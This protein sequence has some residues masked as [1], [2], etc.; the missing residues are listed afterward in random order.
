MSE[1]N[2]V[3]S[4][5]MW[6]FTERGTAQIFALIVQIILARLL[7]PEDFGILAVLLVFVNVSNV[8]IQKGFSTA[9]V[10]KKEAKDIDLN[11]VLFCSELFALV[12]YILLWIVAPIISKFYSNHE[13]INYI[14]VI[15]I[16]LFFGAFYSIE[17]S[18]LIR[19]MKFRQLFYSS[20][21]STVISGTIGIVLAFFEM[22]CW[23]LIAQNV[24]QQILFAFTSFR[25]CEWKVKIQYSK[26]SFESIFKFGSKVLLSEILYT[27]VENLRTLLI[28]AKFSTTD[29]AYYDRGQ[30]YPSVAMRSIYD[31]LGSVLLPV[32][33]S[34]QDKLNI[35]RNKIQ[36]FLCVSFYII[37][38]LFV[39]FA[40]IADSFTVIFLTEKWLPAVPFIHV[41][42][43]YQLGIL[44]YCVLRHGL[45]AIGK[46]DDGLKLEIIKDVLTLIS[47]IIGL[48][49]GTYEIA[50]FSMI[51]IWVA[52]YFYFLKMNEYISL[53]K[54]SIINEFIKVCFYCISMTIILN[55]LNYFITSYVLQIIVD[56][57][58]GGT[59]Y[60]L[61]SIV[62][63]DNCFFYIV[64]YVKLLYLKMKKS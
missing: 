18:I 4:S 55:I 61:L 49:L 63:K 62:L 64:K 15:S 23:A 31:A 58:V 36:L 39:G 41:F 42:C 6:K 46:T 10:Q 5:L 59:I 45:Y 24:I 34:V 3:L 11:T 60:V 56:V 13:L 48:F 35:F 21:I 7:S 20:F 50:W 22:G 47:A 54:K 40:I 43:I 30:T 51:S 19:K 44:P 1:G 12:I 2:K 16:S 57:V 52:T 26:Q 28:G 29:L 38:P 53:N 8:L 37:A 27:G 9:L 17:N 32:L 25:F 14:R 33:S